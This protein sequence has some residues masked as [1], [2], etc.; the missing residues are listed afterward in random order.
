VVVPVPARGEELLT[1]SGSGLEALRL[2]EREE[3]FLKEGFER[4]IGI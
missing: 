1:G 2:T 4:V 3:D